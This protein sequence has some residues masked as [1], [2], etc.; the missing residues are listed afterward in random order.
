MEKQ[1]PIKKELQNSNNSNKSKNIKSTKSTLL[2]KIE[3]KHQAQASVSTVSK[4]KILE[5]GKKQIIAYFDFI[6]GKKI[7]KPPFKDEHQLIYYLFQLTKR[8]IQIRRKYNLDNVRLLQLLFAMKIADYS[9]NS[10]LPLDFD[11]IMKNYP[12]VDCVFYSR[13][14]KEK[15]SDGYY[16]AICRFRLIEKS[17]L[18]NCTPLNCMNSNILMKCKATVVAREMIKEGKEEKNKQE[19]EEDKFVTKTWDLFVIDVYCGSLEILISRL[20]KKEEQLCQALSPKILNTS[21][22]KMK[23]EPYDKE[24]SKFDEKYQ[25][26]IISPNK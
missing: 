7:I 11:T 1:S 5:N 3:K 13:S 21:N 26:Y 15:L 16:D 2:D 14:L 19:E 10:K 17:K 18:T 12:L 6:N 23:I 20:F 8:D 22:N 24:K 9:E 25:N 4:K